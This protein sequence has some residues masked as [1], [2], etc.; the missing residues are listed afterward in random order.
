MCNVDNPIALSPA[1][2]PTRHNDKTASM[3]TGQ[4]KTLRIRCD[5]K[6]IVI[7]I[8]ARH[9]EHIFLFFTAISETLELNEVLLLR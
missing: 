4:E 5:P 3:M 1:G 2:L 7:G 8:N 9:V 6:H